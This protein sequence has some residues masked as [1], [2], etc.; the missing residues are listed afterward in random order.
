M[1]DI[2]HLGLVD[3]DEIVIDVAA[4]ELAALDHP[5]VDIGPYLDM[6][7]GMTEAVRERSPSADTAAAQAQVLSAV[8][9]QE[10]GFTGDRDTYDDPA[11]ADLIEVIDRRCGL[12]VS[13]SILYA[14]VAR[15]AG[16]PA[17]VLNTPGHVLVRLVPEHDPL[18]ID[19]FNG[20]RAVDRRQL[21]SLVE[22]MLGRG[23]SV[24]AEHLEPMSNRMVLVRLLMNQATRAEATAPTRALTLYERITTIAP[25]YGHGWWER[26]RIDLRLG[27]V[28]AAR[29]SLSAMLEITRDPQVRAQVSAALHALAGA[30]P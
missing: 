4:L 1:E 5:G 20:G 7:E 2:A 26:A 27:R 8:I 10:E 22:T 15:G 9:A 25:A 18:L 28:D 12:P 19:P 3:D 6:I 30:R 21:A 13:L 17:D 16:W 24:G 14:A 11:N 29:G 23:A